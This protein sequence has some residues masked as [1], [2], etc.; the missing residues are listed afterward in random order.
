MDENWHGK[1]IRNGSFHVA[2]LLYNKREIYTGG[3]NNGF[4]NKTTNST[5]GYRKELQYPKL[6]CAAY[7]LP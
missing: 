5:D 7:L 3:Q 4:K 6:Q 1:K 2:I